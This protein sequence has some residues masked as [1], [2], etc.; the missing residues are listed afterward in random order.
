MIDRII[1]TSRKP[2]GKRLL[3]IDMIKE[4]FIEEL[5]LEAG[6]QSSTMM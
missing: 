5:G 6:L 3:E 1:G 4:V 2:K